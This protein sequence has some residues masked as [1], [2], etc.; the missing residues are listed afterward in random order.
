MAKGVP[1]PAA[2]VEE[3]LNPHQAPAYSGPTGSV[4]GVVHVSGD[5]APKRALDIP[6]ACGE[7]YATYG[8][9][10]RE[11]NGRTLADVLVAVTAYD[12]YIPPRGE[13]APVTIHGC[14]FD[15]R[16]I[17][18]EYGQHIEVSNLDTSQY[19][20]PTLLGA[21][22]PAQIVAV[23][24]GDAVRLYPLRV[25]HYVLAD[26]MDR[27]WMYADVF[28]LKYATHAVT[29]LDGHFRVSGLPVGKAKVSAY[30]PAIDAALHPDF[31]IA[32][33]TVEREVEIKADKPTIV[34]FVLP[35]KTPKKHEEK[36]KPADTPIIR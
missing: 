14:A 22:H 27:T 16:T 3:A 24:R 6:F 31:G 15:K 30:L 4:E 2:V 36:P 8:K 29:G 9:A 18:L 1:L 25:G 5:Q 10:F 21:E 28:V 33:P 13:V 34:D 32:N 7:A 26:G 35:Y 23:P 17:V 20:L 11:G 19:F 12:G